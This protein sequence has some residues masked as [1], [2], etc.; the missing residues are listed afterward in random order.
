MNHNSERSPRELAAELFHGIRAM[1]EYLGND[2]LK[3]RAEAHLAKCDPWFALEA[4]YEQWGA[5]RRS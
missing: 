2:D 1:A 4:M 3:R 5:G